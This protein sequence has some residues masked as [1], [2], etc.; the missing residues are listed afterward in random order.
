MSS[1]P[2]TWRAREGY[3]PAPTPAPEELSTPLPP[4][5]P[6][7]PV[8]VSQSCCVV[9]PQ[10]QPLAYAAPIFKAA[11]ITFSKESSVSSSAAS[12][13][14]SK[15]TVPEPSNPNEPPQLGA[16][17]NY[18]FPA[19]HTKLHIFNKSSKLWEDKHKGKSL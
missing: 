19:Q 13:H 15:T 2:L 10:P 4:A 14:S 5:A 18:M 12:I 7:A 11:S 3:I 16:G 8:V 9:V 1:I 17:M 6:E